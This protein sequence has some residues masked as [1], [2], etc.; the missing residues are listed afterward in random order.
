MMPFRQILVRVPNWVGDA[1]MAIPAIESVR[2]AFPEA[3]IAVL[4]R[5][6]VAAIYGPPL[7]D[8]VIDCTVAPDWK[9]W[10]SRWRL[11][12]ELRS[13]RFDAAILLPNAF[14]VALVAWLAAIPVRIGYA[15]KHRGWLLTDAVR[16]PRLGEIPEHQRFHYLELLRRAGILQTLPDCPDIRLHD[17][18]RRRDAGRRRLAGDWIGV[19]PGSANGHAK[20]W[21][22]DRFAAA[23]SSAAAMLGAAVAVFGSPEDRALCGEVTTLVRDRGIMATDFGGTTDLDTFIELLAACTACLTNDSGT[24]HVAA[25][26]GVPTVAVFG[27]TSEAATGPVGRHTA[28][29][30]EPVSCS[31][32]LLHECPIDHGCM[33]AVAAARVAAEIVRQACR[34]ERVPTDDLH[35]E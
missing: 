7:V 3:R 9:D 4:A 12:S 30:R 13:R 33:K 31:P 2:L 17:V 16:P 27:P 23:A 5:P 24:M 22:P 25:A 29:V 10:R 18:A 28:I 8:E 26:L 14:D 15:V 34:A 1:V 32:C 35:R 19:A 20:R 11:A 6:R 21:L